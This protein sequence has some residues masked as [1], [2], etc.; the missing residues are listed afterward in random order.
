MEVNLLYGQYQWIYFPLVSA[1]NRPDVIA[2]VTFDPADIQMSVD[3]GAFTNFSGSTMEVGRGWYGVRVTPTLST[4]T[5][6][7]ISII[8][9]SL[10]KAFDDQ[11]I[12]CFTGVMTAIDFIRKCATNRRAIKKILGEFYQVTFDDNDVTELLRQELL[13]FDEETI[14]ELAGT[15]KP[16]IRLKSTI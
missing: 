11:A 1:A 14:G 12:A 15:T 9:Q 13:T 16:S 2:G 10:V 6:L 5:K 4:C 7:S 8:D 3:G